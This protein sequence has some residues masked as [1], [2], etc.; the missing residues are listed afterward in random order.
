MW[1]G[2]DVVSSFRLCLYVLLI[3]MF[4]YFYLCIWMNCEMLSLVKE[5]EYL[6]NFSLSCSMPKTSLSFEYY[7]YAKSVTIGIVLLKVVGYVLFSSLYT[8]HS[9][10]FHSFMH[11]YLKLINPCPW[12]TKDYLQS[13]CYNLLWDF[14]TSYPIE[15]N[16]KPILKSIS[17][18]MCLA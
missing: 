16:L 6:E 15:I 4:S 17:F 3:P 7:V 11:N 1:N 5:I 12:Y 9:Y 18:K 10:F 14:P 8:L 2:I 13:C